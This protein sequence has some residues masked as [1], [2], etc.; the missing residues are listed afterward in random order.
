VTPGRLRLRG[1]AVLLGLAVLATA[2]QIPFTAP[3][4]RIVQAEL[5][6][7]N[8]L[9]EGSDVRILGL[10]VGSVTRL[11]ARGANVLATMA[12]DPRYEVPADVRALVSPTAL[13]GERFVQLDPPYTGGPTLAAGEVIGVDRVR[14]P[15]E[16]DEV[17]ASFE[18]FLA[19]LDEQTLA[20][21]VDV[22]AETLAGQGEGLNRLLDQGAT[23]VR[24]LADASGDINA[25]VRELADLNTTLATREAEIGRALED[26]STVVRTIAQESDEII[27]GVGNLRRLTAEIRPLTEAHADR[28]VTDLEILTTTLSTVDRNLDRIGTSIRGARQ[29]FEGAGR[30]IDFPNARLRLDD[31][32]EPLTQVILLR[33]ADRLTGVCLRLGLVECADLE[34][35][36]QQLPGLFCEVQVVSCQLDQA[37]IRHGLEAALG[38]LPVEAIA[39]LA[40]EQA[41]RQAEE[42]AEEAEAEGPHADAP[43]AASEPAPSEPLSLLD[44]LPLPDPRLDSEDTEPGLLESFARLLRGGR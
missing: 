1:V 5:P 29:L 33:V 2:C 23:T 19:G 3:A 8:N 34:F 27:A 20:D 15:A 21:L 17:L 36:L 18:R 41:A 11:E 39:Q 7:S 6:R 25:V 13:L 30:S 9:F 12:I 16:T 37:D 35:W 26:W 14:V 31:E 44:R 40:E 28:L 24:V 42:A 43:P 22:L 4:Q 10:R 38:L 32:G